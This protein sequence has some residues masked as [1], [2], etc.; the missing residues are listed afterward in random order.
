MSHLVRLMPLLILAIIAQY[1][2]YTQWTPIEL[3]L[4]VSLFM[5]IGIALIAGGFGLYDQF[6]QVHLY[7]NH[8]EVKFNLMGYHEEIL[9]RDIEDIDIQVTKHAY[10]NVTLY[11]WDGSTCKLRYL[12]DV[13]DLKA[14][15]KGV[16]A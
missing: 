10:Y 1:Y 2:L 5:G 7:R 15:M 14:M 12:D 8:L 9:Y 16:A 11:L 6:H 4:D 3:A 13:H